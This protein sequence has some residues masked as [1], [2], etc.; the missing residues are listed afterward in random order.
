MSS[1]LYL[2]QSDYGQ[3]PHVLT[4]LR[5]T[6]QTG[7][8]VVLMGESVLCIDQTLPDFSVYVL[9]HDAQALI[10]LP[11]QVQVLSYSQ[12]ADLCLAYTRCI[13]LK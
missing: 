9:A 8:A 13:R 11:A 4:K 7:D 6:Y 3:T 1:C 5:Q 10:S 12:F 2:I